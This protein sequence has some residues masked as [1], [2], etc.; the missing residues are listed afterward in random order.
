MRVRLAGG[1]R[2]GSGMEAWSACPEISALSSLGRD[3]SLFAGAAVAVGPREADIARVAAALEKLGRL[4]RHGPAMAGA[5]VDLGDGFHSARLDGAPEQRR[6]AVL[7]ALR[8]LGSADL[9][10]D[11]SAVLAALFGPRATKPVGQALGLAVAE[12][13]PAAVYLAVAT[14][15]ILGPE[16]LE[17][18]L[19]LSVPAH[20][21]AIP[22]G[23]P[24]ALGEYLELVLD[25]LSAPRRL[26]MVLDL[27][28]DAA[29]H[30][31]P[32]ESGWPALTREAA[33]AAERIR[34]GARPIQRPRSWRHLAD[35]LPIA[36][37]LG[38]DP[39]RIGEEWG[40]A[41]EPLTVNV[42]QRYAGPLSPAAEL[43][44][45]D[46]ERL[47]GTDLRMQVAR[48][49]GDLVEWAAYMGTCIANEAGTSSDY[50]LLA[51]YDA[52]DQMV[53]NV[54]VL[55]L[56][57]RWIVGDYS[58]LGRYNSRVSAEVHEAVHT[59]EALLP[60]TCTP[61]DVVDDRTEASA[62]VHLD[63]PMRPRG[64]RSRGSNSPRAVARRRL[65]DEAERALA[66]WDGGAI[67][68]L[69]EHMAGGGPFP[70]GIAAAV[71]LSR[72]PQRRVD[73]ALSAAA[74]S[75]VD[76][77][78][79]WRCSDRRPL[80]A[81]L[82]RLSPA[83]RQALDA[84]A[85]LE[86][87]SVPAR[88]RPLL[89]EQSIA[90]ARAVDTTAQRIR[91]AIGAGLLCGDPQLDGPM[92]KT[93]DAAL[94]AAAVLACTAWEDQCA[95]REWVTVAVG[96]DGLVPGRVQTYLIDRQGA[97]AMAWA[98]AAE[99]APDDLP[100]RLVRLRTRLEKGEDV[101]LRIPGRWLGRDGW[102]GYWSRACNRRS[103]AQTKD[104]ASISASR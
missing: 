38:F 88:L 5:G 93:R 79:L 96:A 58:V 62:E 1:L 60:A 51:L 44:A 81:S 52:A 77:V 65:V 28:R 21:D 26:A 61:A 14:A 25:H 85:L 48:H 50:G 7:A 104:S 4:V 87:G 49:S 98:D 89:R 13:R 22:D 2:L 11:R 8:A 16:Q 80:R 82:N 54:S 46:G 27:W 18:V 24:S 75:S 64:G 33:D 35:S 84:E 68:R 6:D 59:W 19:A 42:G 71:E 15:E 97:W 3:E 9:L 86:S 100:H 55:Y 70:D 73:R 102:T 101:T 23:L 63:K 69:A 91:A 76:L 41:R 20:L 72:V 10:G 103:D 56:N 29:E 92:S 37:G 40:V 36:G 95:A 12:D 45:W 30:R 39:E 43:L 32:E 17:Q 57:G 53:A 99:L 34:L 78:A 66:R 90:R 74:G 94:I 31:L 67:L 47:P 83:A